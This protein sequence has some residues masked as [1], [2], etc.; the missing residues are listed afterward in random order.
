VLDKSLVTRL[1]WAGML[2]PVVDSVRHTVV[3]RRRWIGLNILA[4]EPATTVGFEIRV[5]TSKTRSALAVRFTH[6]RLWLVA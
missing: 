4:L 3:E 2:G 1:G 6:V 5:R